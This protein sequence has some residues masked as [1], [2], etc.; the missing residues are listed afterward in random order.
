MKE[1]GQMLPIVSSGGIELPP[2]KCFLLWGH[3]GVHRSDDGGVWLNLAEHN[4]NLETRN[5]GDK[6]TGD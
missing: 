4:K 3:P 2:K 5:A 1:C 6:P